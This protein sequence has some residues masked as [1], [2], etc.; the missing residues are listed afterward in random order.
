V[1]GSQPEIRAGDQQV[2]FEELEI[3]LGLGVENVAVE[4]EDGRFSEQDAGFGVD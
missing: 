2:G 1:E 4:M 3:V